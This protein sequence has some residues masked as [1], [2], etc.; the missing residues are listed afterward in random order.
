MAD[1]MQF[2]LV[3]PE[4]SLLSA[5][6]S[7]VSIPGSEGDLTAGPGHEPTITTLRP[8]ILT[9]VTEKGTEEFVV[10]GGF[11]EIGDGM[12]VLAEKA[13]P[14]A[15][16]DQATYE[17]LVKEAE[18]TYQQ[19]KEAY[20]NEPGPVDDAAKLLQDMVAVGSHIGLDPMSP[21]F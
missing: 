14:H 21:N 10:T 11:V 2:D 5:Q 1:T 3:S 6:A 4:R 18:A 13:V 19:A 17:A 7:S 15:D 20:E 16:M 12:T 8:G 9:V